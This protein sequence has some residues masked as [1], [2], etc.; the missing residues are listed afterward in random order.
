LNGASWSTKQEFFPQLAAGVEP[1][2]CVT[3]DDNTWFDPRYDGA[4][5]IRIH[6]RITPFP[7]RVSCNGFNKMTLY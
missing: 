2:E 3:G 7:R 1:A 4:T 6:A 5:T